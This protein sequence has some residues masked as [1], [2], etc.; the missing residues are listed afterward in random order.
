M[1]LED[2]RKVLILGSGHMGQ[3]IGTVTA[4]AGYD[5][6][7]YDVERER[8]DNALKRMEKLLGFFVKHNKIS[9]EDA[10]A[11]MGRISGTTDDRE[12]GRD[13]DIISESVPED[14]ELKGKVFAGFNEI[15]PDRTV[16]TTNTSTLLPSMFADKT[17]RPGKV[18]ALHFHDVRT[19]TVVDVMPHP[20]TDKE[21][22]E[23]VKNF[24]IAIGQL[25][26]V[27]K[28]ENFGFVFNAMLTAFFESALTLAA[29]G[30]A[31][32]E[33]IDRSW[34]GVLKAPMGPF[35]IMD[36]VGLK[37]I[38]TVND[39]WAKKTKNEQLLRNVEF[40]KQYVDAGKLGAHYGGGFY[41]YPNP[42]YAD[43]DFVKKISS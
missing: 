9:E 25:P 3:Q 28:K 23:L 20:G 16:F 11:A 22:T 19:T 15:C 30:V 10:R 13:A 6:V 39:Y 27:L 8:V 31:S 41:S 26:I 24:A 17:G 21:V 35:A 33:D 18:C 7:M 12:A 4:I 38:Y 42:A 5:V 36:Q 40:V 1:K 43:P 32:I 34:V 29:N 14:P 2:I 37:T